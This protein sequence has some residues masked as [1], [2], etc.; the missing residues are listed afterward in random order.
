MDFDFTHE[1]KMFR[2][3]LREFLLKEFAPIA[4]ERDRKGPF[5]KEEAI[6]I[7]KKF[8]KV[9]I[10]LDPES[11]KI[12]FAEDPILF[13]IMAEEIGRVWVS[14][15]PLFGMSSIPAM[16]VP[17]ASD[18]TKDRLMPKLEQAEFI[19][20][21]AETEPEAGCDTSNIKTTARL[22]GDYYTINGTK[23]WISNGSIAD[24]ALVG[25]KDSLTNMETFFLV[26][27]EISPFETYELHK[28]GWKAAPTAEMFFVDCR[29]PKENELN[30]MMAKAMSDPS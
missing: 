19:G 5:T 25:A 27:R 16:F 28:I 23:T 9:G 10:G 1:E 18:E 2:D 8:K 15:L 14:L 26:E 12:V 30:F 11:L 4:D 6:D 20:C 17:L 13:G 24:A 3:S 29:V 22:E 7:M 21:F